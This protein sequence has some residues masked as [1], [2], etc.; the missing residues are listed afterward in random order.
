MPSPGRSRPGPATASRALPARGSPTTARNLAMDRL[1]RAKVGA[2]KLQEVAVLGPDDS[3][4]AETRDVIDVD[5]SGVEDDRLRLIFTC[6]HPALSASR[7]RSRSR[8]A[9]SRA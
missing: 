8:C 2:A 9:R 7:R 5:D 4:D 6:C 1:R 3:D